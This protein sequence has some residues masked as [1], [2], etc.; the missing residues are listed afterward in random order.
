[1]KTFIMHINIIAVAVMVISAMCLES[2][3]AMRLCLI[4]TS[5]IALYSI[6][7]EIARAVY[8]AVECSVDVLKE[9]WPKR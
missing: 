8:K 6:R 1:M 2:D 7:W 4:S 5:Y 9:S 3:V